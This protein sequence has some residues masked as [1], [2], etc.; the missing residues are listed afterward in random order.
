MLSVL[1]PG[2]YP[3][4]VQVTDGTYKVKTEVTVRVKE[5]SPDVVNNSVTV[6]ITGKTLGSFVSTSLSA[7]INTLA[8]I[9]SCSVENVYLWS[10]QTAPK[11]M[12][13]IVFAVKKKG[14][15]EFFSPNNIRETLEDQLPT[16]QRLSK[17]VVSSVGLFP[18]DKR[19]CPAGKECQNVISLLNE[20]S[21]LTGD[22]T[23]FLSYKKMQTSKC[24][25]PEGIS[26]VYGVYK[27]AKKL[28]LLR[29]SAEK[30][31][32]SAI[33]SDYTCK[34]VIT[35]PSIQ[36]RNLARMTT[37]PTD[38][39]EKSIQTLRALYGKNKPSSKKIQ[40]TE[41]FM[42][43]ENSFLVIA[44]VLNVATA[45]AEVYAIDGYC[46]GAPLSY[47]DLASQFNLNNE[48]AD[49]IAA[50]TTLA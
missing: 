10:I 12:L 22:M 11:N 9:K 21:S 3:L 6:R 39:N 13:D 45:T 31:F 29:K 18:C 32:K 5:I 37:R 17:V 41:M 24:I 26:A 38:V 35:F 40:A 14:K 47:Q 4:Q 2:S 43:G 19:T 8:K 48:E 42:K 7:M 28:K 30:P 1:D 16:F 44:R 20:W 36:I 34:Y 27:I 25:C 15:E 23:I 49:I 33:F 50:E 46:S